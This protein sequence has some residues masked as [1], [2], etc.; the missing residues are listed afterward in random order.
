[1]A[2]TE[3]MYN[4]DGIHVHFDVNLIVNELSLSIFQNIK[5]TLT[6]HR[7]KARTDVHYDVKL[8]SK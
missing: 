3:I 5:S 7:E 1:M 8:T 4:I 6:L 2:S